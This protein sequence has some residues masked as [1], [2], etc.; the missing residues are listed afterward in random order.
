[1]GE[2]PQL[3]YA[4]KA[5]AAGGRIASLRQAA[6]WPRHV[7]ARVGSKRLAG[8]GLGPMPLSA[9]LCRSPPPLPT[10]LALLHGVPL[11]FHLAAAFYKRL[12]GQDVDMN[13][14]QE[15]DPQVGRDGEREPK[16]AVAN[17]AVKKRQQRRQQPLTQSCNVA[18][19]CSACSTIRC[20]SWPRAC[21]RSQLPRTLQA[22]A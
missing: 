19:Q 12:D 5:H 14:L 1:M 21:G 3:A 10:G 17:G 6:G 20:C 22:L 18:A 16:L 9:L 7:A 2:L 4:L 11:G 15:A 13:D 8:N